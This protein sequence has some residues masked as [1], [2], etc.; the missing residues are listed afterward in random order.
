MSFPAE[1]DTIGEEVVSVKELQL[2]HI[3]SEHRRRRG[4]TQEELAACLGVSKAAVSKWETGTSYPDITQLP[5]LAALFR[6][7]IDDLLGYQPQLSRKELRSLRRR[8]SEAFA[9]RPFAEAA[10]NCREAVRQYPA[11][12][13]LLFQAA[14]LLI[15]HAALAEGPEQ[16]AGIVE[17]AMPLFI[18]VKQESSD[19]NLSREALQMEAYCLLALNRPAEVLALLEPQGLPAGPQE[20]LLAAAY[21]KTG[22]PEQAKQVLQAGIYQSVAG[23]LNLLASYLN[24]STDDPAA[25]AEAGRRTLAVADAFSLRE[26]H[27]GLLLSCLLILAQGYASQGKTEEAYQSLEEYTSLAAGGIYPLKLHG[28]AFFDRLDSWLEEHLELDEYPPRNEA[29]IRRNMAQALITHPAFTKLAGEPRF[30]ELIQRLKE[31]EEPEEEH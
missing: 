2:G 3:L 5:R 13:P 17:E 20:P 8:L 10:E 28:D 19:P 26:L 14:S 15:N 24:L 1:C 27:P 6:I 25:F 9:T 31:A 30:Q 21:Q 16:Q 18:Q 23:L 4:M 11:C 7:S 22:R 12:I 29:V